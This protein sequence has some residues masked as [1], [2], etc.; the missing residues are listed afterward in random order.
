MTDW[1]KLIRGAKGKKVH[2]F[3]PFGSGGSLT[4]EVTNHLALAQIVIRC[5]AGTF[6][7]GVIGAAY[8]WALQ[9]PYPCEIHL[10]LPTVD[11]DHS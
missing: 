8:S 6:A 7:G 10:T 1:F 5:N 3:L 2:D 4:D 11:Q 9:A